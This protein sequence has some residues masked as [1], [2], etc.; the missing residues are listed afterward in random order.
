MLCHY[1]EKCLLQAR[2]DFDVFGEGGEDGLAFW[3][4]AGGYNHPVRFHAA[5]LS[6]REVPAHHHFA[7][8]ERLRLVILRDACANLAH[9]TADVD[10]Q[11]Q[12]LVRSYNAL[13]SFDLPYAHLDLREIF[14]RDFVGSSLCGSTRWP[15]RRSYACRRRRYYRLLRFAFQRFHPLYS[16]LVFD[17]RKQRFRLCNLCSRPKRSPL[18]FV[19]SLFRNAAA[20]TQRLPQPFR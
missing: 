9:F 5:E 14:N 6:R 1:K 11:L 15:C 16:F 13:R 8:D 7:A 20:L 4:Y 12:Q 18:Q 2:A 19:N 10:G 17:S 3:S